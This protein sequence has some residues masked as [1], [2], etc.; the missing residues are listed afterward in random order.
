MMALQRFSNWPDLN[1]VVV[2][3]I[4]SGALTIV[5][6]IPYVI[7]TLKKRTQPDRASWLIWSTIG[8]IAFLSQVYEG[9]TNSLWF[10]GM[11]VSG[12]ILIFLLSIKLGAGEYLSRKNKLIFSA[13]LCGVVAWYLAETAVYSLAISIGI[14]LLGGIVTVQKAYREPES[15]TISTW[16]LALLA[17]G[18]AVISVDGVD[19]V[20]LAF[21]VYLL[22]LYSGIVGAMLL[23]RVK[24]KVEPAWAPD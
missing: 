13:A 20:L 23:G 6:Y 17:S 15:E 16:V 11:Q 7:D 1:V 19:W 14:G 2:A 22:A 4:L 18:C 12:T 21:P 10:A 8:S 9:A 5:G 24:Q 3:G